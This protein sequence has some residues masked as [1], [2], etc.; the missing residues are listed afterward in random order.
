MVHVNVLD[1]IL[2]N[3]PREIPVVHYSEV[4]VDLDKEEDCGVDQT[5]FV[6]NEK[7][8]GVESG[9]EELQESEAPQVDYFLRFILRQIANNYLVVALFVTFVR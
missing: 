8:F 3:L 6:V 2:M 4:R 1:R 7:L 5:R 9:F